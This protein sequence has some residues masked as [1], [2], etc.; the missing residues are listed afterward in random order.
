MLGCGSQPPVGVLVLDL[1]LE[2]HEPVKNVLWPRGAAWNVDIHRHDRVDT[3]YGC[4]VVV[5]AT[6]AGADAKGDH[7]LRLGHLFVDAFQDRSHFVT[8][9]AHNE[10]HIRLAWRKSGE[11]RSE[12]VDVVVRTGRGHVLHPAAR[13]HERVLEDRKLPSPAKGFLDATG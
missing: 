12:A 4:V 6:C 1:V 5:K 3:H 8:D 10:K 9:R 7:P 13:G 11:A 2:L